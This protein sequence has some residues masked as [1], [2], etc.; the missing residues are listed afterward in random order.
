MSSA[1]HGIFPLVSGFLNAALNRPA[2]GRGSPFRGTDSTGG[3]AECSGRA[4]EPHDGPVYG[5]WIMR[6]S[7]IDENLPS[8]AQWRTGFL[9]VG[10]AMYN[11]ISSKK[12]LPLKIS[13]FGLRREEP[14]ALLTNW[15][16]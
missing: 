16:T 11:A 2:A 4:I 12:E 6:K 8:A 14:W 13:R 9:A 7:R 3:E 10:K 1:N 15:L 5:R